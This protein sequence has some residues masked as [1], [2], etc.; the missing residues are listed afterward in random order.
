MNK[1]PKINAVSVCHNTPKFMEL[2]IRSLY[3]RNNLDLY[4]F[5]LL[6]LDNNSE[7]DTSNLISLSNK[8]GFEF[9]QSG[10]KIEENFSSHGP[11]LDA[12]IKFNP[13]CDYYLLLDTDIVFIEE[14]T[15]SKM[16]E[17]LNEHPEAFGTNPYF[18]WDGLERMPLLPGC[19]DIYDIRLHPCCGLIKNDDLFRG[20]VDIIGFGEYHRNN[21]SHE[22]LNE[23]IDRITLYN[24]KKLGLH[25][26]EFLD[27][28]QLLT[29]VLKTHNRTHILTEAMVLHFF[30]VSYTWS[31]ENVQEEKRKFRDM[32]LDRI[33]EECDY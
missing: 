28:G 25:R 30:N 15:I 6:V 14:Q 26:E 21:L 19:A 9:K 13:D 1:K 33:L 16:I 17:T 24:Y 27:V 10:Y 7:E 11:N 29:T 18:S 4:N 5:N 22:K 12:F 23:V 3:L 8:L 20:L 31:P 32:L 2:M